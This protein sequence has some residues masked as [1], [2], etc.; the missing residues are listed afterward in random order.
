[1]HN[2]LAFSRWGDPLAYV[3]FMALCA[4]HGLG[5]QDSGR[6]KGIQALFQGAPLHCIPAA[7]VLVL[8][9]LLPVCVMIGKSLPAHWNLGAVPRLFFPSKIRSGCLLEA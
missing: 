6:E 2:E 9:G 5:Q 4:V 7:L 8:C 1:M 3:R